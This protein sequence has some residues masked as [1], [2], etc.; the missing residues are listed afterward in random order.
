MITSK[1]IAVVILN[2]NGKALLEKFL[3]S[4][5]SYS[6]KA[7]IYIADNASTDNSV[8]FV[9]ANYPN[10]KVI[11]HIENGGYAKGYND[12]LKYVDEPILCLLNSDV[13]VTEDWL[14]PVIKEF[15]TNPETAIVQPK[16]LDYNNRTHFEYAGAGGGFID[17]YAYPFCRGRLFDTV[18]KD[19]N[20]Y[21]DTTEIFWA[22][23]ACLFIRSAIFK[24]L[25][26]FDENF[27]AHMEEIDLC[28][29]AFNK[30]YKTKYVGASTVYHVGGATLQKYNPK[31]TYLNFRNSLFTL[32][33][34]GSGTIWLKIVVRLVLDGVASLRFLLL[35]KP[36][37]FWAILKSHFSFYWHLPH[38]SRQRKNLVQNPNYY[39]TNSIV[40]DY[41][42]KGRK[43]F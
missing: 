1:D 29:R 24:T 12:A 33:K 41:Y 15:N 8:A 18:E 35:L 13:E 14:L 40:W 10:L 5:I 9:K 26:G 38:L 27:F 6:D 4:V 36:K 2:W 25:N 21:N 31:K 3:P 20:Q 30:G 16:L 23:G 22:S 17:K 43:H 34:N 37:H 39:Q 28:W 19:T 32:F 7:V 11:Q 42:I